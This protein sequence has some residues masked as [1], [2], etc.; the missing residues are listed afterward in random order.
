[1][2]KAMYLLSVPVAHAAG[3]DTT[4]DLGAFT[5]AQALNLTQTL[6]VP[7]VTLISLSLIIA[8]VIMVWRKIRGIARRPH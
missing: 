8:V 5:Q 3:F 4:G 2:Y 1:M 7:I 6:Y